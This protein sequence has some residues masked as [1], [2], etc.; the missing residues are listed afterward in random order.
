MDGRV[1]WGPTD[2][3]GKLIKLQIA[4]PLQDGHLVITSIIHSYLF[5]LHVQLHPHPST[6]PST[7]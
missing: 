7:G 5:L 3:D 4:L 1:V 2:T 6:Q